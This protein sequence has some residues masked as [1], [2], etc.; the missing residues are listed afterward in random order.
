MLACV[1]TDSTLIQRVK[2]SSWYL[3]I[4]E[5]EISCTACWVIW[6]NNVLSVQRTQI[7]VK[8]CSCQISFFIKIQYHIC[9]KI[10]HVP[11]VKFHWINVFPSLVPMLYNG[12]VMVGSRILI[13]AIWLQCQLYNISLTLFHNVYLTL[14]YLTL[15][16]GWMTVLQLTNAYTTMSQC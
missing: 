12:Y 9:H 3:A 1:P 15:A 7:Y 5:D 8:T 2:I 6:H 16:Y 13:N 4:L 10:N 14:S 11:A